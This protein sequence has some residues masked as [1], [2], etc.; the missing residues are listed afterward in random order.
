MPKALRN[1]LAAIAGV[2]VGGIANMLVIIS[3]AKLL[4]PPPGVDPN[5][6]ASIN[7]HIGEYSFAQLLVPFA[8]HAVGTLVGA[9]LAARLA[10]SRTIVPSAVVGA[11]FLAGGVMAVRM[12]PDAPG[13]F[14]ALDLAMAYAPMAWLG[15][16]LGRHAA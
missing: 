1:V 6:A 14:V 10:A 2:F 11:L 5:D 15:W 13:W 12:I 4:P 8:A 16:R 9:A 7:A 3:G